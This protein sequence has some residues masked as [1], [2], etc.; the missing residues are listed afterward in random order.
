MLKNN[1]IDELFQIANQNL[2]IGNYHDAKKYFEK[3]L[4]IDKKNVF[5]LYNLGIVFQELGN[6]ERA[7]EL[8]EKVLRLKPNNLEDVYLGLGIVFK[9]IGDY[10]KSLESYENAIRTN[11]EYAVAYNNLGNLNKQ[12]G[13]Y[14]KALDCFHKAIKI[15]P[16]YAMA[17]NNLGMTFQDLGKKLEAKKSFETAIS[18][19]SNNLFYLYNLTILDNKIIDFELKETI[20]EKKFSKK[21]FAYGCFILSR[22]EEKNNNYEEEISYL[23]SGHKLFYEFE[24]RNYKKDIDYWFDIL[25]KKIAEYN[26]ENE[27]LKIS[28]DECDLIPIFIIGVP[29][30][31]STLIEKII[32]SGEMTISEGEETGIIDGTFDKL[33][34]YESFKKN[35]LFKLKK[36]NCRCL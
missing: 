7:I 32:T 31:G 36:K 4:N 24:K 25:P 26:L 30:C 18:L 27:T 29:R 17:H 6:F 15:K 3:I 1:Q 16:K 35:D 5:A 20:K 11:P 8:Y 12:L 2:K 23:I 22:Y 21:N 34:N 13:F 14:E 33:I 19:D 9:A 10:K 28:K